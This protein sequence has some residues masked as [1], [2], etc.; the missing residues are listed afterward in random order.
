M[1][2]S[3]GNELSCGYTLWRS[4]LRGK[5]HNLALDRSVR[6]L[7]T[8]RMI[9]HMVGVGTN[10][11]CATAHDRVLLEIQG[12]TLAILA[13]VGLVNNKRHRQSGAPVCPIVGLG[14]VKR[15]YAID[16]PAVTQILELRL[17]VVVAI[18]ISIL[19]EHLHLDILEVDTLN[20][21]IQALRQHKHGGI[22]EDFECVAKGVD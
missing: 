15:V 17:I 18:A 19:V 14:R 12:L 4:A 8:L 1:Q 6:H 20:A 5:I 21:L 13:D 9:C 11:D 16:K 2:T 10:G 7:E 3:E 22:D